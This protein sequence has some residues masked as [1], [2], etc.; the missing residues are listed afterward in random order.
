MLPIFVIIL[1]FYQAIASEFTNLGIATNITET[2]TMVSWWS[3]V[4]RHLLYFTGS[5]IYIYLIYIIYKIYNRG[6]LTM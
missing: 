5:K 1:I 2:L 6:D 3:E 4:G